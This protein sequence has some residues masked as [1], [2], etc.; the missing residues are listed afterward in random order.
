MLVAASVAYN[1]STAQPADS[2]RRDALHPDVVALQQQ[3]TSL[4]PTEKARAQLN[5]AH[6]AWLASRALQCKGAG[7][8][9]LQQCLGV[10][11]Q[12][13]IGSLKRLKLS[14]LLQAKAAT[15]PSSPPAGFVAALQSD[16][17]VTALS[18]SDAAGVVVVSHYQKI[19]VIDTATAKIVREI[20][21]GK[22]YDQP[23]LSVFPNGRV[24]LQTYFGTR[25]MHLVD[26]KDGQVLIESPRAM[27]PSL[28]LP[29]GRLVAYAEGDK[30]RLYDPLADRDV[31][32]P[33]PHDGETIRRMA[34]SPDGKKIATVT[35]GGTLSLWNVAYVAGQQTYLLT[36]ALT[37]NTGS[38]AAAAA[39]IA[40][41]KT[42]EW[43]FTTSN[44]H[45]DA[46]VTRWSAADLRRAETFSVGRIRGDMLARLPGNDIVVTSGNHSAFGSYLMFLDMEARTVA[47]G[48]ARKNYLP[49]IATAS[50]ANYVFSSTVH[51][52][53]RVEV[54]AAREFE[55]M[56]QKLA[57]LRPKPVEP[58]RVQQV[59]I[60]VLK[61]F[62]H[63]AVIQAIFVYEGGG[64]LQESVRTSSG[65]R[66]A[67]S[68][69]L[70][71][72]KTEKPLAL[73]VGSYEP[74]IWNIKASAQA[75]I[76]HVFVTGYHESVVRGAHHAQIH[77]L[78]AR[79]WYP[80]EG[81]MLRHLD[82]QVYIQTGKKVQ[83]V[84]GTYRGIRYF[85]GSGAPEPAPEA[86]A[87]SS[88]SPPSAM[89]NRCVDKDG[90]AFVTDRRCSDLGYRQQG[91]EIDSSNLVSPSGTFSVSPDVAKCEYQSDG[92]GVCNL[93]SGGTVIIHGR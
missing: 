49:G 79:F 35:T 93:D 69:D 14:L 54:P 31:S 78:K 36:R 4:A 70:H 26:L 29:G 63:D 30:L 6:R 83:A 88:P 52:L 38:N 65:L 28:I 32:A 53:R 2:S 25:N 64:A 86:A 81:E 55:A 58:P 9:D 59:E 42:G 48:P 67:V 91:I 60:P 1:Q 8:G 37:T 84:Q 72:G 15:Q 74:V 43:I 33:F 16:G 20:P 24:A 90:K 76:T 66:R 61:D 27:G 3:L 85:F 68:V 80:G 5:S 57:Q 13:R 44:H 21:L 19:A 47:L 51:E 11:D 92:S 41:S 56:D 46:A 40:F 17:G 75:R 45:S 23:F 73:V 34:V 89:R 71:V 87:A 18:A 39:A 82:E 77:Q 12:E 62:P 50:T 10:H 7:G 22:R